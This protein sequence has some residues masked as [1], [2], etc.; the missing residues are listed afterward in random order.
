MKTWFLLLP[1]AVFLA[2]CGSVHIGSVTHTHI[3]DVSTMREDQTDQTKLN[4]IVAYVA[5]VTMEEAPLSGFE[6]NDEKITGLEK[7]QNRKGST[8][9]EFEKHF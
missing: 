8:D 1:V 5:K 9:N 4:K 6:W 7:K 3:Y 2:G